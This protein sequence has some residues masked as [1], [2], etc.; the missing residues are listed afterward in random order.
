VVLDLS[1]TDTPLDGMA[2]SASTGLGGGPLALAY[3]TVSGGVQMRISNDPAFTGAQWEPLAAVKPW[4]L[5]DTPSSVSRVYAQFRDLAL[6][7]SLVVW[8]DIE[9]RL[10]HLY[11]PII[12]KQN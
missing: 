12:S 3:N 6:N 4:V 8:D 7:E 9:L 11:L 2:E 5:V 1:A 10:N